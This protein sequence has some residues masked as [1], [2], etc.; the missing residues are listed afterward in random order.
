MKNILTFLLF[1]AF[2]ISNAQDKIK[3]TYDPITGSQLTRELCLNCP[4]INA[5]QAKE[6]E[7]LTNEDLQKFSPEDAISYYPN[8]VKEE[9]YL[10][11]ELINE[12][13]VFSV[14]VI[15]ITGQVLKNYTGF[16]RINNINIPFQEFGSGIY[17][18][19]VNYANGE[20]KT[21]KIIKK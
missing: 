3:F 19:Q 2:F 18:V 9:L 17:L 14:S 8:P 7:A 5:K 20:S 12:N 13:S 4:S 11:W 16:D 21:I 10:K 1:G 6:I 15:S